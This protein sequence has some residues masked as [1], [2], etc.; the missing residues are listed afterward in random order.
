[1]SNRDEFFIDFPISMEFINRV[2]HEIYKN[3]KEYIVRHI[4][5]CLQD[6]YQKHVD[7]LKTYFDDRSQ[8][9]YDMM[10]NHL[11]SAFEL[12][13]RKIEFLQS[14]IDDLKGK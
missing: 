4:V 2:A 11:H 10:N 7:D 5:K 9:H 3:E 13:D 1:L 12:M 14:Q 8:K 6:K